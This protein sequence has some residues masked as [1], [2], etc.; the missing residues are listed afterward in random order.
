[1]D[2]ELG[3]EQVAL[4]RLVRDFA[5]AE[6]APRAEDLDEQET[7]P[8][9]LVKRA[10]ELGLMGLPFPKEYGGAGAGTL[11][12]VIAVE[13]LAR[14][15]SSMAITVA[16]NV[17]LGGAPIYLFG[18]AEQ[19][20]QWL[21]PL[22]RGEIL[23]SMGLTEPEAGSDAG[24]T[25]TTASLVGD[26]WVIDGS[27]AFITNS[28]TRMSG[29]VTIT[30]VTGYV[31]GQR[32]VSSIIV[33]EGTPGYAKGE[34]YKKLGWHASDTHELSFVD[35]RVPRANL[36]GQRGNG[37]KQF[38]EVLDAGRISVAAIGVGMA[39]G[40]LEMSLN[41]ARQRVQSGQSLSS[42]QAVQFKLADMATGVELA[43][44]VTY[45]A[46]VL[47]DQDKPFA[48]EAS[49]AKLYATEMAV[50]A[51]DEGVQIH[52]GYGVLGKHPISR[53]FRDARVLTIGEGTS[54]IQ[55]IIIAR[56][57]GC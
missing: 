51:A 41:H 12:Y 34:P 23:G 4:R 9:D 17:S 54:E 22:A 37:F 15:D 19:K 3:P 36:L 13:E 55:R 1:M 26:Q 50:R 46:A 27:K 28:G 38:M 25:T 24:A 57:L 8:Y 7:F 21:V 56:Q 33:P 47:K 31:N 30:A 42:L 14:V 5:E 40:C 32:E 49:M 6:I 52:G 39:Q 10:G 11:S 45:K 43:R 20:Q 53:F 16:A 44:L 35:C 29:F 2:F 18:T 48:R